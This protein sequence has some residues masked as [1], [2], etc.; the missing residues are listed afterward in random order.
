MRGAPAAVQRPPRE[1][2]GPPGQRRHRGALYFF[3][4][5][6][7]KDSCYENESICL[8]SEGCAACA[9]SKQPPAGSVLTA[10]TVLPGEAAIK[11]VSTMHLW[12]APR[13]HDGMQSP[14]KRKSGLLTLEISMQGAQ[15]IQS[16]SLCLVQCGINLPGVGDG[17]AAAVKVGLRALGPSPR[18]AQSIFDAPCAQCGICLERVMGKQPPSARKFGLLACEHAFCLA[19]I[20]SWRGT[21]DSAPTTDTVQST[22]G[23]RA[24]KE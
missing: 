6:L 23:C 22:I 7:R 10:V 16:A 3:L 8:R 24:R 5:H 21:G 19:C 17:Q 15:Q 1:G 4:S 2:G 12:H 11:I 18:R 9:V 13:A 20:R 14:T